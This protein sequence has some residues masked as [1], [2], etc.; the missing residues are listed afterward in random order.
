[1][2]DPLRRAFLERCAKVD[3]GRRW[4]SAAALAAT[5]APDIQQYQQQAEYRRR[6]S[7]HFRNI[8][9]IE[10]SV[11]KETFSFFSSLPAEVRGYLDRLRDDPPALQHEGPTAF[12]SQIAAVLDQ[13]GV[14]C[15]MRRMAGPLSLGVVAK[16]T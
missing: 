5:A 2:H 12:A 8:Y 6:R 11:R 1:M 16:A 9:V 14:A 15:D 13:L 7:K 3:A 4:P 10:A